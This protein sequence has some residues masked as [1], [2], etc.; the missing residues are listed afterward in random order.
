MGW[1]WVITLQPAVMVHTGILARICKQDQ[2]TLFF[3]L[4]CVFKACKSACWATCQ[5]SDYP[6][7]YF[8]SPPGGP[9][10]SWN[11]SVQKPYSMSLPQTHWFLGVPGFNEWPQSGFPNHLYHLH[12]FCYKTTFLP[13]F[14]PF[15]SLPFSAALLLVSLTHMLPVTAW[16]ASSI[17]KA[18]PAP[19]STQQDFGYFLQ[20]GRL[21]QSGGYTAAA[22][23]PRKMMSQSK[24]PATALGATLFLLRFWISCLIRSVV[25][26]ASMCQIHSSCPPE[27]ITTLLNILVCPERSPPT[28][29]GKRTWLDEI[30]D[31]AHWALDMWGVRVPAF[32]SQGSCGESVYAGPL[33]LCY[34]GF[35]D[36]IGLSV[37]LGAFRA[38]KCLD[39]FYRITYSITAVIMVNLSN[40]SLMETSIMIF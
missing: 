24:V 5:R 21:W 16:D 8:A 38:E 12:N 30:S 26:R 27:Q 11:T 4:K 22:H 37:L 39:P 32:S 20:S 28:R 15:S 33:L 14:Y 13:L 1:W 34:Y 19:L 31:V 10:G 18:S 6:T 9:K 25:C 17:Q 40:C 7:A 36:A 3:S 2:R 35:P 29:D 23:S